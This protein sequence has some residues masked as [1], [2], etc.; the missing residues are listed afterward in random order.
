[1]PTPK[2]LLSLDLRFEGTFPS[3]KVAL[4]EGMPGTFIWNGEEIELRSGEL[5]RENHT[6]PRAHF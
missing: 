5:S 3:G 1:M 6:P 4:P 2:G